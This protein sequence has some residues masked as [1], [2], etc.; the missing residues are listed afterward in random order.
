MFGSYK[1]RSSASRSNTRRKSLQV[2][3]LEQRQMMTAGMSLDSAGL[4]S[5]RG[6]NTSEVITVYKSGLDTMVKID[7]NTGAKSLTNMGST[8]KYMEIRANAGYDVVT[9]NTSIPAGIVGGP[10]NDT[11]N[12]GNARDYIYGEDGN[13]MLVG[14]A[15]YDVIYGGNGND[16]IYGNAGK[17]A[18]YGEAGNDVILGG[19][20]SDEVFGSAGDDALFGDDR[21]GA[22]IVDRQPAGKD[23]VVGSAGN[24]LVYGGANDDFL[25]GFAGDDY[26]YGQGGN[27]ILLGDADYDTLFGMEGDD[28]LDPGSN[29]ESAT[30]GDG[31]D[32]Y[33]YT[34]VVGG[35]GTEDIAQ[36]GSNNCFILAS[37]GAA[38][39]R[40]VDMASRIKYEGDCWYSVSLFKMSSTGGYTPTKVDV[41][42]DGS[43]E[44]TDPL[45]HYRGQEGESWAIIM[46][47][48]LAKLLNVDLATTTGG[49]AGNV[50]GAILGRAPRT[51]SWVDNSGFVSPVLP[52]A[53]LDHL[54]AV[55]NSLPTVVGT[56]NS[57]AEM[58]SNLFA[59]N[60]VYMVK[61][62]F[63]SGYTYS[64]LT[65][66]LIPQYTILLANPWG[67]DTS[68]A[69]IANGTGSPSG[70]NADGLIVLSGAEF[71]RN[72]DEITVG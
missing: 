58:A 46:N 18:L 20:D 5:I 9:N 29:S 27:D 24:D 21:L 39:S 11:I 61:G 31:N 59:S 55:G 45:A 44:A 25:R 49:Y 26:I 50:L 38:A 34:T 72:F 43:L 67:T 19:G 65:S 32:F 60:H 7:S 14:N 4:L 13:D 33:G 56:R 16:T 15:G 51:T 10:G 36:G 40:G 12:G 63:I 71:K 68:D 17:D 42:F 62:V 23:T 2:E 57:D 66:Q 8:V 54:F 28:F 48:A 70:D 47:R 64:P 41:Y 22:A 52:D 37:M 1:K 6:D 3:S 69:R 30:G 53:I 35:A